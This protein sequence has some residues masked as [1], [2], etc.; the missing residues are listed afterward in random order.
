MAITDGQLTALAFC[1]KLER[2]DGAGLA[3]TS[4]DRDV[5]RDGIVY[6]SA[7]GVTPATINRSLGLDADS[8]ET[9]GALSSDAFTERDLALGRWNDASFRLEAVD[10]TAPEG[11][12]LRLLSGRLGEV[13]IEGGGFSADLRGATD[14]L[15]AM[16]CPS[17]SPECRAA[18][19][20]RQCRV[21]L[22][23]RS[24]RATVVSAE[25][26]VIHLD[27]AVGQEF[28]F[29]RLRFLGGE[30][31]GIA[32]AILSVNGNSISL[33]DIPRAAVEAETTVSVQEGC[34]KRFS[35][36]AMRFQ[37]GENFRGEPHLPG[38]D[39]LTRYPGA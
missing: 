17:T 5:E 22:S 30:N 33:R 25:A 7:P 19:G 13:S 14:R 6:R 9:A 39:L 1:W 38:T 26:N 12:A 16:P 2:S 23:G 29:G 21:D 24:V 36:C 37:N 3:L 15:Q 20:D 11:E 10:W 8:G 18:F 4:G 35:T 28:L 27:R 34:D 32:S 31:C